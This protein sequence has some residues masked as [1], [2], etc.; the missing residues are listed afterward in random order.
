MHLVMVA[1]LIWF[2]VPSCLSLSWA[3]FF[4]FHTTPSHYCR[5]GGTTTS[6]SMR[7]SARSVGV[8]PEGIV[9]GV[10]LGAGSYGRV[11]RGEWGGK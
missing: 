6:S 8:A 3:H 9:L 11:Y 5:G 2:P 1:F 4:P 10:L 7:D